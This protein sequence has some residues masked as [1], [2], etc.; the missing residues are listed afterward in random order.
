MILDQ[1][2]MVR[3]MVIGIIE[4]HGI[5]ETATLIIVLIDGITALIIK[6]GLIISIGI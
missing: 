4:D 3:Q 6:G 1:T 5:I 2:L